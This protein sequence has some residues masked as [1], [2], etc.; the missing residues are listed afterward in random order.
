MTEYEKYLRDVEK[1]YNEFINVAKKIKENDNSKENK[2]LKLMSNKLNIELR[3][4]LQR[5]R[6]NS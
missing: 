4:I 6:E 3:V 2:E 5:F 1:K